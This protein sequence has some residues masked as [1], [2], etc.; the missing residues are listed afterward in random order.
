M[1][2]KEIDELVNGIVD[3][4]ID[5]DNKFTYLNG[6]SY[7]NKDFQRPRI[8]N[9]EQ[10]RKALS[11][12]Y[13]NVSLLQQVSS[14]LKANNGIYARILNY[15]S[16]LLTNNHMITP[17]SIGKVISQ[18]K[19]VDAYNGAAAFVSRYNIKRNTCWI[20]DRVIEQGELYT[21]TIAGN[22]MHIIQEI[23]SNLC[24]ITGIENDVK[25]YAINLN[26]INKEA[27]EH[28]PREIQ[29]AY[30]LFKSNKLP[31]TSLINNT[32]YQVSDKGAAF[33]LEKQQIKGIPFY[34]SLFDDLMELEDLKDLKSQLAAIENTVLVH[35]KLPIDDETG[36]VLMDM[37]VAKVYHNSTKANL[38]TGASVTTNP[39]E[40][41]AVSL[42]GGSHKLDNEI[43]QN[44]ENAFDVA[45]INSELFNGKKSSNTAITS[46]V[47]V[48]SLLPRRIQMMVEDWIN[49]DLNKNYK[50][51]GVKW[52]LRFI[53]STY[54]DRE[55][56]SNKARENMAYGGSRFEFLA[57]QGYDPAEGINLLK[58]E[59]LMGLD[60]VM[61]PQ[62]TSHTMS[63]GDSSDSGRPEVE[64]DEKSGV[65]KE[66]EEE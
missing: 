11:D 61:I 59:Q 41:K 40:V 37:K 7:L 53:D 35:Q 55:A 63:K 5:S 24:I 2:R 23:P 57:C 38:P 48:D 13:N 62:A 19:M 4:Y 34:S 64:V 36:K 51:H 20:I 65:S 17:T 56:M 3:M 9:R 54:F 47:V 58:A 14:V 6:L 12:P 8:Y 28:M 39:L 66:A 10:V 60:N 18:D 32:Y 29:D 22:D 49:Y 31:A 21:Y 16:T 1:E 25:R 44:T 33:S 45:G 26:G 46:G 43:Y 50:K 52:K 42:G 27:L 30:R 15:N